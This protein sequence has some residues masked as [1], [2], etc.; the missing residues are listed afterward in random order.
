MR[1][2]FVLLPNLSPMIVPYAPC[3]LAAAYPAGDPC[4]AVGC[5]HGRNAAR[6]V[7]RF[8]G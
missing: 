7:L 2:R 4:Q 8:G 5:P 1:A 3:G 6:F